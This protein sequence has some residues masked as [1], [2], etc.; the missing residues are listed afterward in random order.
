MTIL[1]QFNSS[2]KPYWKKMFAHQCCFCPCLLDGAA[3]VSS[4]DLIS[5]V[6]LNGSTPGTTEMLP[7]WL[8]TQEMDEKYLTNQMRKMANQYH[9]KIIYYMIIE[10]YHILYLHS[11]P[12]DFKT[13]YSA[14][15]LWRL[16]GRAWFSKKYNIA[17][18]LWIC[19]S[20][21]P[22]STKCLG[23]FV[24]SLVMLNIYIYIT[25]DFWL[26]RHN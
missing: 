13:F 6:W 20:S 10:E 9:I 2:W 18:S 23:F 26:L 22:Q 16:N 12:E 3:L 7:V 15:C 21:K 14:W 8:N 25:I 4:C 17:P 24:M 5:A 1:K 11:M 19:R